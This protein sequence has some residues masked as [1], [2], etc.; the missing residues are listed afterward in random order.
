MRRHLWCRFDVV[1]L[2]EP[3]ARLLE[4]AKNQALMNTTSEDQCGVGDK[5]L[6]LGQLDK[7]CLTQN[8]MFLKL[9]PL[10]AKIS[11]GDRMMARATPK[12]LFI[13]AG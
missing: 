2:V 6:G 9:M 4:E 7:I 8:L 10:A 11:C 12:K 5:S 13:T 1:D 3:N